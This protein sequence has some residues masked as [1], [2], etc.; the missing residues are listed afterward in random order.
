MDRKNKRFPVWSQW[1][2]EEE[3]EKLDWLPASCCS[4][5]TVG[6]ATVMP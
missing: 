6:S 2:G 1:V 4:K 5:V 3:A